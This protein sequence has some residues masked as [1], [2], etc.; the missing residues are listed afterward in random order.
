MKSDRGEKLHY[1]Y[2]Q[3][4]NTFKWLN[5]NQEEHISYEKM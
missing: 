2:M 4:R 1:D 3:R 5:E